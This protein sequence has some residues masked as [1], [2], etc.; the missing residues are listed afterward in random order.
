MSVGFPILANKDIFAID[1]SGPHL[2]IVQARV[3]SLKREI[4]GSY[5]YNTRGM[6]DSEISGL[7]A[8]YFSK[9]NAKNPT[10]FCTIPNRIAMTKNIEVPSRDIKEVEEI[11]KL[12][13]GR[14]TPLAREEIVSDYI[15]I[16]LYRQTYTK[17]LLIIINRSI[18]TKQLEI[19]NMAK[20]RA[21]RMIFCPESLAFIYPSMLRT[22]QQD[23][24]MIIAHVDDDY[25]DFIV[26][27][28]NKVLFVRSMPIGAEHFLADKERSVG[29]FI[30]QVKLSMETYHGE[31]IETVPTKIF[32]V[33]AT[34]GI[35]DL[36]EKVNAIL[37][38]P[39]KIVPYY[40][41]LPIDADTKKKM[42]EKSGRAS[43]L[44]VIATILSED[45]VKVNLLPE[46]VKFRHK[47]EQRSKHLLKA[48]VQI[49]TVMFLVCSLVVSKIYFHGIYLRRLDQELTAM[50]PEVGRIE[51]AMT[52]VKEVKKYLAE[53][54]HVLN[55]LG[56]LHDII[57]Q[58]TYFSDI[59][60]DE[61]GD[62]SVKGF[63]DSMSSIFTFIGI[64]EESKYFENV[65]AKYTSKRK[66]DEKDIAIFEI[67]GKVTGRKI[68]PTIAEQVE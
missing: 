49:I 4:I 60:I 62:F 9:L 27:M 13:A 67:A 45:K 44:N 22:G 17:I 33:G 35:M 15:N 38:V 47:L 68:K 64:M 7:I 61:N 21:E 39:A 3:S 16:G 59:R 41:T 56:E 19:L 32:I 28:K 58:N 46:E 57:P 20:L 53:Q 42:K 14:H 34:E 23:T 5:D 54:G 50:T 52:R 36:E 12:Q 10:I 40:D 30:E 43:F 18:I 6:S 26:V 66:E 37:H 55:T 24:P 63:S 1:L 29:K 8:G 25:T 48:G 31:D 51:R 11:I 2:K 65:V